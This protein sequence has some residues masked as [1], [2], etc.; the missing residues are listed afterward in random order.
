MAKLARPVLTRVFPRD[1]AFDDLDHLRQQPVIWI[2]GPAGCGKTTLASSY[3]ETRRLPCLWYRLDRGDGDSATFFYYLG[4]AAKKVSPRVKKPLPLLTPEYL[5]GIS[6]FA[7]RYFENLYPRLRSPSIV[8]FDN[9]QE[10]PPEASFHEI[11]FQGLSNIPEGINVFLISRQD[12]HPALVRLE[13][14]HLMGILPWSELRLTLEESS[15]IAGVRFQEKLSQKTIQRLHHTADG[16]AA[17]LIL[18]LE[19]LKR[20]RTGLPQLGKAMPEEIFDYFCNEILNPMDPETQ[21]FLLKTA[22]LPQMTETMAERLTAQPQAGRTLARLNR[23]NYFMEKRILEEPIYSYHPLFREFLL[24]RAEE[25]FSRQSLFLLRRRAA[26]LL[27]EHGQVESAVHLLQEIGDWETM[28]QFILKYAPVMLAQAR[29]SVL[30]GWLRSL[31]PGLVETRPWLSYWMGSCRMPV[32]PTQSLPYFEQAYR[33]MK[34]KKDAAGLFLAWSRIVDAVILGSGF[35]P[36]SVL[37]RYLQELNE[38]RRDYPVYPSPEIEA[39]VASSVVGALTLRQPNHL[40]IEAW[41]EKALRLAQNQTVISAK[42][43]SLF[44]LAYYQLFRGNREKALLAIDELRQIGQPPQAWPYIKLFTK[45]A[46]AMHYSLVGL[47]RECLKAVQTGLE[48]S[49]RSGIIFSYPRWFAYAGFAALQM[50]DLQAGRSCLKQMASLERNFKPFDTAYYYLLKANEALVSGM[51]EQAPLHADL[52][53]KIALDVGSPTLTIRCH[54]ARAR[55]LYEIGSEREAIKHL[56][57]AADLSRRMKI[58]FG[59]FCCLFTKAQFAL[60]RGEDK[61]AL[62]TLRKALTLGRERGFLST[63]IDRPATTARVCMKAL[64]AGIEVDYVQQMIRERN[65]MPEQP[66]WHL[67]NWPWPLKVFTLGRFELRRDGN[68]IRFSKK[69]QQ[70]PISMLKALIAFG[71]REVGEDQITDALWPEADGD[72]AHQSLATNLHRLR[73]LLGHEKAIQH[74]ENRLTLDDRYCWVDVWVF[75]NLVE[76]ADSRWKT[77]KIDSAVE[78]I[79]KAI[80]LYKG[81]FLEEEIEQPWTMSKS[82]RLRSMFLRSVRKLGLYWQQSGQLEKTLEC[83]QKG[84]E[85]DRLAEEFYQGLMS[86]YQQ[87]GRRAEAISAYNRC[88]KALSAA[89]GVEPSAKTE[90]MYRQILSE[91]R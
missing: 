34:V 25:A 55:A 69:V 54:L 83:Y 22:L 77:G 80:G 85:V 49:R 71:G 4:L 46:E 21:D 82:E 42:V 45:F 60:E 8:V 37:D 38:L 28:V 36:L 9:Y 75:E 70:K 91:N 87:L 10:V 30:E 51:V 89:L 13:A 59:E 76:Q 58:G 79:E 73:Q 43:H 1:R 23:G 24:S 64:E 6:T 67:E 90:T 57:K 78:L 88:K 2:S 27:E 31:P 61:V 86:C 53:L 3:I 81:P 29:F 18:L 32:D 35:E 19:R 41:A 50:N 48:L 15:G 66:P 44:F 47:T 20:E 63:Y 26:E 7:L 33:Q 17:G 52:A 12:P 40:E 65:L 14:N 84:L 72:L 74:Q 68:P 56:R 11:I 16:W 5:Q 62:I 39:R